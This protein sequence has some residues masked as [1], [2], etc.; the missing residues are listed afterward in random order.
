M[1]KPSRRSIR[2][3]K[4][5]MPH[6][7]PIFM[8]GH[9]DFIRLKIWTYRSLKLITL[10]AYYISFFTALRNRREITSKTI[11]LERDMN[12][13]K[14]PRPCFGRVE[15]EKPLSLE[16]SSGPIGSKVRIKHGRLYYACVE[17]R[18]K[19]WQSRQGPR[20]KAQEPQ[21]GRTRSETPDSCQG[22]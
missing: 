13:I 2:Y 5:G 12:Q 21:S 18:R 22:H 6:Q 1:S 11:T 7:W 8:R 16:A 20:S 15:A 19:S 10:F 4:K 17:Q 3:L 14:W 9:S